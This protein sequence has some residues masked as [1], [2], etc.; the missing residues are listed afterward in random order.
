[1]TS[2][3]RVPSDISRSAASWVKDFPFSLSASTQFSS[4]FAPVLLLMGQEIEH[5]SVG[6]NKAS[7]FFSRNFLTST[8]PRAYCPL[9]P[10]NPKD[11]EHLDWLLMR[12]TE[13]SRYQGGARH[14][15]AQA[16]DEK[17]NLILGEVGHS[18]GT[19]EKA[20]HEIRELFQQ[21]AR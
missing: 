13:E 7:R 17:A 18:D 9:M 3:R 11:L 8:R 15:A 20:L 5:S 2:P 12:L 6:V 14:R 1:M 21:V 4:F 19:V 10:M 16:D